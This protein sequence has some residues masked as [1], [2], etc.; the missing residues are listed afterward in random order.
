MFGFCENNRK[1]MYGKEHALTLRRN[2]NND[3]IIKSAVQGGEIAG[4]ARDSVTDGK[5]DI[6]KIS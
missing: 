6:K 5:I 3:A 2:H 1:V 4:E